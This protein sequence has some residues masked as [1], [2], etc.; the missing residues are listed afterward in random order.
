MDQLSIMPSGNTEKWIL[1]LLLSFIWGSSFILMKTGM[2]SLTAWQVASLRIFISGL[3]LLPMAM[4]N[5]RKI[6]SSKLFLVFLSGALGSLF[7]AYLFCLAEQRID[8]ALAGALNAM[9]P[10]FTLIS[11]ILFF[12]LVA[13]RRKIT[14]ILIACSGTLFLYLSKYGFNSNMEFGYLIFILMATLCY[15]INVNLVQ[16]YLKGMNS[17]DIVSVALGLCA[18]PAL[19]LLVF[20]GFFNMDFTNGPLMKSVGYS[21]ILGA[22]GTSAAS[23]LFYRLIKQAGPVFASTV[24]Y[25]IPFVALGW[26]FVYGENIVWLQILG[27]IVILAGVYL[28]NTNSSGL[29]R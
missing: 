13:E 23:I 21:L 19:I 20:T 4:K 24:T 26:G 5:F 11:G 18:V 16:R 9:T 12:G 27:L 3:V 1:F 17:I 7:P 29:K 25:G 8:S 6:P 28:A 15:G 10:V 2:V 22:L 14:G